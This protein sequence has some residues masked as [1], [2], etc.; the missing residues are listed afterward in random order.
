[1]G[2]VLVGTK[3]KRFLEETTGKEPRFRYPL[4]AV[5]APLAS[6]SSSLTER[7]NCPIEP[8][9]GHFS[10]REN[11]STVPSTSALQLG[12]V[13]SIISWLPMVSSVSGRRNVTE[14][15]RR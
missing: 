11:S 2:I 9:L 7:L 8:Q 4:A 10:G 6:I 1:V 5:A 12:Q 13:A 3:R 14:W 15:K